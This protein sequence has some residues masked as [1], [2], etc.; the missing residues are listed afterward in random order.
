MTKCFN[1]RSRV[2]SD[3]KDTIH[4][5]YYQGFNPRSRVGSDLQ[6]S[7]IFHDPKMF[8]S[9]LPRRERPIATIFARQCSW[10]QSTLPRRERHIS[11]LLSAASSLFQSTLP[12]RERLSARKA[13]ICRCRFNPRSRVGS[14]H[15]ADVPR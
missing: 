13:N 14:D 15:G 2:G 8:Q 6:R 7:V 1:P 5:R 9:T 10:F 3:C 4:L 12:R 11:P